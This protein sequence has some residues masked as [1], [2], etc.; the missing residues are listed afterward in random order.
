MQEKDRVDD[1]SCFLPC[2]PRDVGN[3]KDAFADAFA[4][5][6]KDPKVDMEIMQMSLDGI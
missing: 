6:E 4:K 3:Q 1:F 5:H 2:D